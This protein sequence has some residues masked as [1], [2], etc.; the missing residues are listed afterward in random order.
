MVQLSLCRCPVKVSCQGYQINRTVT[1]RP[2][3]WW[4]KLYCAKKWTNPCFRT[5]S[6]LQYANFV[7]QMRNAVKKA[8]D[9]CV[10]NFPMVPEAHQ[11][12]H[13][14]LHELSGPTIDPLHKN[15]A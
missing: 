13:S 14:Y 2:A 5:V 4:R 8:M 6:C 11:N 12:N 10:R 3:Q 15:L 1:S 7:L 9:E